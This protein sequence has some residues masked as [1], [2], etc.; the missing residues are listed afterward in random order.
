MFYRLAPHLALRSSWRPYRAKPQEQVLILRGGPAFPP[1]H[2]TTRLSLDLLKEALTARPVIRLLDLGCGSGILA[3]AAAALGVSR[4]VGV[5]LSWQAL[6][7][8]RTNA[9]KNGLTEA[10]GWVKGS[11]ESLRGP[12]QVI[13]ANLPW[14]VHREKVG[15]L[16]RL[17]DSDGTLILSGFRDTQE[18]AL[19]HSYQKRGWGRTGRCTRDEWLPELPPERSFTWVAWSLARRPERSD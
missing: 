9:E 6:R 14:A 3:L 16:D 4:V 11:T 12:F 19:L 8:S 15:E 18:E 10:V 7:V 13:V 17:A 2:P 1:A 5:D